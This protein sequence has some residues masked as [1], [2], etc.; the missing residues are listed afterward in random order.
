MKKRSILIK[1]VAVTVLTL[2]LTGQCFAAETPFTDINAVAEKDK[3]VSLQER[4]IVKGT[5]SGLFAPSSPVTAAQGIQLIVNAFGLNIDN[6]RFIKEP[7]ATDY[8]SKANDNAWYANALIIASL[9]DMGLPADLDP[10]SKW[11]KEDFTYYL[12]RVMEK[13]GNLPVIKLVPADIKDGDQMNALYSGAVQRALHYNLTALNSD[14][15]F[16][17][18]E[19]ITRSE[20]AIQ[21]YNALT[22]LKA[23]PVPM[24]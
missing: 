16:L 3:I 1:F 24:V 7:K 11:T 15:K 6:I 10:N 8:F 13:Q 20:A 19:S 22:Y 23:H 21:V 9:N 12:V 18:K 2:S 17:P 4:G 14:G 5:G